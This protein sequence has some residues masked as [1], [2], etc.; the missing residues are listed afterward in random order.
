MVQA[1]IAD[2]KVSLEAS[3]HLVYHAAWTKDQGL[4]STLESSMAK[5]HATEAALKAASEAVLLHGGPGYADQ[6][7][8][9]RYYRDIK[10]L[11]IYERTSLNQRIVIARNVIGKP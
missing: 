4:P 3:R 1:A 8:V 10:G 6:Y 2:M 5:L 9:E 7:P 11:Q